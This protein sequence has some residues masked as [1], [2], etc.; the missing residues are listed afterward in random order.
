M[1]TQRVVVCDMCNIKTGRPFPMAEYGGTRLARAALREQG[2]KFYRDS[3]RSTLAVC[4]DCQTP[5]G[6]DPRLLEVFE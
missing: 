2:W 4:N 1:S 5:A 3:A 6:P